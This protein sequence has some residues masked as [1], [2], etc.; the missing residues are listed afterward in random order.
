[1]RRGRKVRERAGMGNLGRG[2]YRFRKNPLSTVGLSI[3]VLMSMLALFAPYVAPY[4]EDAGGAIHFKERFE[5]PSA[6]HWFGTDEAG[7]DILTR[8]IFGTRISLMIGFVVLS[9][10]VGVG[11]PLG[12]VA[13]YF[14]GKVESVIMRLTDVFLAVPS[15]VLVLAVTAALSRSL[16]NSML[17]MAFT[18]WPWYARLAY[19]ETLSKKQEDFVEVSRAV[20]AS[21][22]RVMFSEIL[23]NITSPI[24]VKVSLDMGMAI[25]VG[26]TLGFLGLGVRPPTPEWGTMVSEGRIY[27]PAYW[28]L[29]MF[30]GLAIFATV[31]GFNLL[32]DG[33]RDFFDVEVGE[34]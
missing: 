32:G 6:R 20:G 21:P 34:A 33:L 28:W 9:I 24:I 22:L 1:M 16:E 11:V 4:P 5:A 3:I 10:G 25:L 14:G 29:S 2:I 18:W 7:R 26:A 23:P 8:V 13:G 31:F 15:L 30:P 17:A 27:L 12:I 19:G